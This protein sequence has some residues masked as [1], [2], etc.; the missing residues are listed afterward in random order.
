MFVTSLYLLSEHCEYG[1][2]R[3]EIIRDRILSGMR[4]FALSLKLLLDDKLTLD[5][6][7]AQAREAEAIKKQQ[8]TL[9]ED[10]KRKR[11]RQLMLEPFIRK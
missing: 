9:R 6:A 1:N 7:I 8:H 4:D 5:K 2:L 10:Q 11:R 3:E